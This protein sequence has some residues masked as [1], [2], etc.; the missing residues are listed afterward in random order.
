MKGCDTTWLATRLCSAAP[1]SS[2]CCCTPFTAEPSCPLRKSLIAKCGSTIVCRLVTFGRDVAAARYGPRGGPTPPGRT[3]ISRPSTPKVMRR[4]GRAPVRELYPHMSL[5]RYRFRPI[6]VMTCA[7]TRQRRQGRTSHVMYRS[8]R[9]ARS[10]QLNQVCGE[11]P[12]RDAGNDYVD[13]SRNGARRG[14][15]F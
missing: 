14:L 3:L 4:A 12:V 7:H 13:R 10:A 1:W 6:L 2:A 5:L 9:R 8:D 15:R 11:D